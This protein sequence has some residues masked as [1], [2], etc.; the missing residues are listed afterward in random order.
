LEI[1][2]V[3]FGFCEIIYRFNQS[4]N[5]AKI[6]LEILNLKYK[7]N[8]GSVETRVKHSLNT[9]SGYVKVIDD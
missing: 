7:I 6:D 2:I 3:C 1:V 9:E 8:A 4:I 5:L